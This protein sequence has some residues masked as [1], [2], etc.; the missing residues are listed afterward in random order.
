MADQSLALEIFLKHTYEDIE[1]KIEEIITDQNILAIL[2][3]G[4]RLRPLLGAISFK[5]CTGGNESSQMYQRFLEGAVA[6]ELAHGA[7]LVHDDIIDGDLTRRGE[8]AFYI[9]TGIDNAI[10]VGHKMLVIGFG[11]SLSHGAKIA[12][13]YVDA[14]GG[15]LDG[16]LN[17]INFNSKDL[18]D[19]NITADSKFFQ[20]YSRIIDLKTATLFSATCKAAAYW[21]NASNQIADILAEYGREVGFAYQ[22]ADDLVDLEK[23]E[24]IDS[25]VIPLLARLEKRSAKNGT[26]KTR[27][28][29]KKIEKKSPEIK[30][31]YLEEISK[32]VN[33]AQMICK[34]PVLPNNQFK[35]FLLDAPF[36][37]INKMLKEIYI[38]I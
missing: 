8:A 34:S 15:T 36:Y 35:T 12:K 37:S 4:K 27:S 22:L 23:G 10:L 6:I 11:L 3:D 29:R 1:K 38:N 19:I 18:Q 2:K 14:W 33:K 13:L 21:A 9:K 20:V 24:M 7:S 5:A 30:K 25:V 17:E 28:I 26:I 16:Q 31:L 32:H